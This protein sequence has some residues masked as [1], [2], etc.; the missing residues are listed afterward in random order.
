MQTRAHHTPA[1]V[2]EALQFRWK[3][4]VCASRTILAAGIR[5]C[6]DFSNSIGHNNP[7]LKLPL[8]G[9]G[10]ISEIIGSVCI[11]ILIQRGRA[12]NIAP[13]HVS[14]K[15]QPMSCVGMQAFRRTIT[16]LSHCLLGIAGE[17]LETVDVCLQSWTWIR[18]SKEML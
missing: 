15:W 17:T 2:R 3:K 18:R 11:M 16:A 10:Y 6:P 14:Y 13:I 5:N 12:L 9:R 7:H 1:S 8:D 4:M